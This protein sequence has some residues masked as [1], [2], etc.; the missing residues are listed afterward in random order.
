MR[1][2]DTNSADKYRSA[3]NPAYIVVTGILFFVVAFVVQVV[4]MSGYTDNV[5][6]ENGILESGSSFI[7]KPFTPTS[8]LRLL[9]EKL[10]SRA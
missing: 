2:Y 8:L 4:F 1:N 9:R 7:Q 6:A 3:F 5:I 10:D